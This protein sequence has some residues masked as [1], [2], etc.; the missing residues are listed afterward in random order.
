MFWATIA[1][2][3]RHRRYSVWYM[4]QANTVKGSKAE[5]TKK[6]H[7]KIINTT[8]LIMVYECYTVPDNTTEEHPCQPV[9]MRN[10]KG[11]IHI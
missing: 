2:E 10:A 6:L 11:W 1:D 5:A 4:L 9:A 7:S 3:N 8:N